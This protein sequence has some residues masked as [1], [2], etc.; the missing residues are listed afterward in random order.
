M[1]ALIHIS[2]EGLKGWT[3]YLCKESLKENCIS[4]ESETKHKGNS[5]N[6]RHFRN[7]EYMLRNVAGSKR[8]QVLKRGYVV[9]T[10]G[11]DYKN[12]PSSTLGFQCFF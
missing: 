11:W 12:N 6:I 2:K 5:Q 7:M 9:V 4:W 8:S 10:K 1:Q 3:T